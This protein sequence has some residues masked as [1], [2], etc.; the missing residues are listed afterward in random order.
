MQELIEI[1]DL[2]ICNRGSYTALIKVYS[3]R[4][5]DSSMVDSKADA[6]GKI[7]SVKV[8]D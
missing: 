8:G 1:S 6:E 2:R 3:L 5:K 7:N 4:F